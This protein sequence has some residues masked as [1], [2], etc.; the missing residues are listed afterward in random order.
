V[1]NPKYTKIFKDKVKLLFDIHKRP[2][3]I[4]TLMYKHMHMYICEC[5]I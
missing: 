3:D 1:K 5:D 4:C 2:Q